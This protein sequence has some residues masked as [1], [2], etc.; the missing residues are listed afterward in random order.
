M[1]TTSSFVAEKKNMATIEKN[2]WIKILKWTM[3]YIFKILNNKTKFLSL[4]VFRQLSSSLL[5]PQ[6]FSRYVLWPSSGVCRNREPTGTSNYILYWNLD[7]YAL[8]PNPQIA[9]TPALKLN[10]IE[11]HIIHQHK[12][13]HLVQLGFF[14]LWHI[15]LLRLFKA[16]AI[17]LE[18]Q[19]WC[20]L[21]HR[22]KDKGVHAFSKI[23]VRK[24]M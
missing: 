7:Y 12:F 17:L 18:V 21:T 5:F 20:Y 13:L 3:E 2:Q 14:V 22:W 8:L 19:Q 23:F 6:H 9:H 15:N 1:M 11:I 24:G 4:R 16:K 10:G